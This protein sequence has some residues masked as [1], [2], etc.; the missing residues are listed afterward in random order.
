V[1][2]S[3]SILVAALFVGCASAPTKN[4]QT[5]EAQVKRR[6]Y[7]ILDAAEKKDF[8]RLDSYHLYGPKFTK[9]SA[10]SASRL[11]AAASRKGEHDGLGAINDL[12]IHSEE[13]KTDVFGDVAVATFILNFSFKAGSGSIEGKEQ[14]TLVFVNNRGSWRITHEHFSPIKSNP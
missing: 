6:L 9:F 12:K 3:A 10:A 2:A 7:E 14:A 4:T 11:D 13:L 5:Q 8:E 1:L